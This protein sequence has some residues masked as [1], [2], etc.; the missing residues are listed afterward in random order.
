MRLIPLYSR[1]LVKREEVDELSPGGIVIPDTAKE[2]PD[3]GVVLATGEG[4]LLDNGCLAPLKVKVG[5]KVLFS[6]YAGTEVPLQEGLILLS[7][8]D[9]MALIEDVEYE[10]TQVEEYGEVVPA[11]EEEVEDGD[12]V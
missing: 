11:S 3:R 4:R 10:V 6:K 7:E 12:D 1:V 9:V 8:D 5:D 2:K